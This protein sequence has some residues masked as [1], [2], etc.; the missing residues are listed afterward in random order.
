MGEL[1]KNVTRNRLHMKSSIS[2]ASFHI[3]IHVLFPFDHNPMITKNCNCCDYRVKQK[4]QLREYIKHFQCDQ[5]YHK[6]KWKLNMK[7]HLKLMNTFLFKMSFQR[8]N[9]SK[10]SL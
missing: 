6:A 9:S 4:P 7:V 2:V 1:H 8:L 3:I 10:L 5:C